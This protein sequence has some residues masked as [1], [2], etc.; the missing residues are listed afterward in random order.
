VLDSWNGWRIT[1][2]RHPMSQMERTYG[3]GNFEIV[4]AEEAREARLRLSKAQTR[5]RSR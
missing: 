2:A 1:I 4:S 3:A 5:K